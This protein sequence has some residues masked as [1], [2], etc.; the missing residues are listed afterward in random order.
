MRNQPFNAVTILAAAALVAGIAFTAAPARS[1]SPGLPV[2]C[3]SR[4]P[5]PRGYSP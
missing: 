2:N 5:S 4:I 3:S 1:L